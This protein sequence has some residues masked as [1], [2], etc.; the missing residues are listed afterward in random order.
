VG[1]LAGLGRRSEAR[2][3]YERAL[4]RDPADL[5]LLCRYAEDLIAWGDLPGYRRACA[6]LLRRPPPDREL[7]YRVARACVLGPRAVGDMGWVVRLAD[8]AARE[9]AATEEVLRGP[10][11]PAVG[12]PLLVAAALARAGRD[13]EAARLLAQP[14]V[15]ERREARQLLALVLRRQGREREAAR[16]EAH[17]LEV[18]D[19]AARAAG[20][21]GLAAGPLRGLAVASAQ[22]AQTQQLGWADWR[23]LLPATRPTE[24]EGPKVSER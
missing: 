19:V 6:R 2:A 1:L 15:R 20:L 11:G 14:D 7:A 18:R 9:P 16:L 8:W 3:E 23:G 5:D 24:R 17:A 4:A 10:E 13:A 22:P 21:A 12:V